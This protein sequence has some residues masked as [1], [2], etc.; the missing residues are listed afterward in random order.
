MTLPDNP[1]WYTTIESELATAQSQSMSWLT[2]TSPTLY[3]TATPSYIDYA[4]L[5]GPSASDMETLVAQIKAGGN[6]PTA[7]QQSTLNEIVQKLLNIATTKQSAC[8]ALQTTVDSFRST[9]TSLQSE[10]DTAIDDGLSDEE[11]DAQAIQDTQSDIE[12]LMMKMTKTSTEMSEES[13]GSEKESVSAV[14]SLTFQLAA[15][16]GTL[17]AA[18]IGTMI[19]SYVDLTLDD[20]VE[21]AQLSDAQLDAE[22]MAEGAEERFG[23]TEWRLARLRHLR[24]HLRY[25]AEFPPAQRWE[26]KT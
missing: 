5:F 20:L 9:L 24:R 13:F 16:E 26:A 23:L 11:L 4:N 12:E 1:S 19:Y 21:I 18:T 2:N 14:A 22:S 25:L 17:G 7:E 10:I 8:A 6:I 15:S 3:A